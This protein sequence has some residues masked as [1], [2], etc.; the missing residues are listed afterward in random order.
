MTL[1]EYTLWQRFSKVIKNAIEN[2]KNSNYHFLDHF[3]SIDKMLIL[4]KYNKKY[5]FVYKK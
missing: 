3:I 5:I 4:I 2:C 1:L